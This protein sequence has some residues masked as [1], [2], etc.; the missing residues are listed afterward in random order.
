MNDDDDSLAP[1]ASR[2]VCRS[3]ELVDTHLRR[4]RT[5][6]DYDPVS[7]ADLRRSL[8][9]N[10]ARAVATLERRDRLPPEI[11][12]DERATGK[13][14]ALQGIPTESVVDAYRSHLSSLREAFIEEATTANLAPQAIITGIRR[15]WEL[16]DHYSTVLTIAH[17]EAELDD[18]RR[19]ERHRLA[20]LHRLLTGVLD[21]GELQQGGAVLGVLANTEYWVFRGRQ[22]DG[23][24]DRLARHL[25]SAVRG[26]EMRPLVGPVD[27]DVAGVST[28]RPAP[29]DGAVVAVAGPIAVAA[30]PSAFAEATR[31]LHAALRYQRSGIVDSSSLS[32]RIAVEQQHELGEILCRR[33]LKQ[34]TDRGAMG[35]EILGTV[36]T[37]IQRSRS[38]VATARALSLHENT[39]RYR[40]SR[41]CE[42]TG[43][44]MS[45]TDT[46]VEVWWALEYAGI[47]E[48]A[49]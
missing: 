31:V 27:Q 35:A 26:S 13:R 23:A 41:F 14:R 48:R 18:A 28:R 22:H 11:E 44:D 34:L 29:L 46:L 10:V 24:T 17:H 9:R 38:V 40:I 7:D 6:R 19:A 30:I 42:L 45:D 47:Q 3:D 1:V 20:F 32:V 39:V 21:P 36:R 2:L 33:Y 12:E 37:W 25:D 4:L 5:V 43:A 8:K 49:Q 16:A 15:L